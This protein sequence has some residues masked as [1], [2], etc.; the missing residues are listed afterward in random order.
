MNNKF[1][2]EINKAC[3]SGAVALSLLAV[4]NAHAMT[5]PQNK[6]VASTIAAEACSEGWTQMYLVA[7]TINN[8]MIAFK[9]TAY[10]VVIQKNQYY[11]Y[12]NPNRIEIYSH[13]KCKIFADYLTKHMQVLH[14]ETDGA[15]FF[16][17]PSERRMKWHKVETVKY[18]SHVYYK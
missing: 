6:V 13:P 18:Q 7:N 12:T 14:D 1:L 15:L 9:K 4:Q 2:T 10:E 11:G 16:R 3:R 5:E 17:Q 8:R